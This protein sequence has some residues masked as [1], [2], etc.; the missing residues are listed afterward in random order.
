MHFGKHKTMVDAIKEYVPNTLNATGDSQWN[1]RGGCKN[2]NHNATDVATAAAVAGS[3]DLV[4]VV[5]GTDLS[6]ASEGHDLANITIPD[7]QFI[8]YEAVARAA[9]NPI[10]VVTVTANAIDIQSV[11]NNPKVG[12]V[13]HAG[14]PSDS[15]LGVG[16]VLFGT[17]VPAGRAIQTVHPSSWQYGLSIFDMNM[18]PGV[19]AFPR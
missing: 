4:V 19:S 3:V 5:L 9:K 2:F 12:G 18:R 10:V 14:Q 8:L 6:Q 1:P 13:V 15:S 7:A 16:D 17:K 11:L